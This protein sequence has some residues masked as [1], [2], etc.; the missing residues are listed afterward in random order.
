MPLGSLSAT[1]VISPGAD[2]RKGVLLQAFPGGSKGA[3]AGHFIDIHSFTSLM[4]NRH[5]RNVPMDA[6]ASAYWTC[7]D[8]QPD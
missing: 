5:R 8:A 3:D 1:P 2:A 6:T 4:G 7:Q